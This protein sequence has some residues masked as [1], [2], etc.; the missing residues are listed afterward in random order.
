VKGVEESV[1]IAVSSGETPLIFEDE[2]H[3]DEDADDEAR[4]VGIASKGGGTVM[5][6][7]LMA[8]RRKATAAK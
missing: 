5:T 6:V 2:R 1:V 7:G 3:A 8:T 4:E